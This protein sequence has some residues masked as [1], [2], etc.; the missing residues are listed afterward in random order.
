MSKIAV[1]LVLL[2]AAVHPVAVAQSSSYTQN[3]IY[4]EGMGQG[5]LYSVNFDHRFTEEF[6]AR[7][8]VSHFTVPFITD[9]GITTIPLMAEYLVGHGAHHLEIGVGVIPAYGSFSI[10]FF[11]SSEGSI[12]SWTAIWTATLGYRYQ[13]VHE[14]VILRVGL[15]P[16]FASN[17]TQFW[18]GAS[19]G[20]AF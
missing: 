16:L 9:L 5:L 13:P 19:I 7:I 10:D 4:F 12:G 15:T 3:A 6:A 8:G 20:W 1:V 18:G 11:G 17:A 2:V 14:G